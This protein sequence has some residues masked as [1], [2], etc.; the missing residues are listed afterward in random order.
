MTWFSNDNYYIQTL[1]NRYRPNTYAEMHR[2]HFELAKRILASFDMV[3][4][5]EWMG[6]YVSH[7]GC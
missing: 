6:W 7:L 3:L 1:T 2:S 4:I 5:T